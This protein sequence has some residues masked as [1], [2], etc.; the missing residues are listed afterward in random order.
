MKALIF[1]VVLLALCAGGGAVAQDD[2]DTGHEDFDK[3]YLQF[4]KKVKTISIYERGDVYHPSNGLLGTGGRIVEKKVIN[5]EGNVAEMIKYH[6][7]PRYS[8]EKFAFQ[9]DTA[10]LVACTKWDTKGARL[11]QWL[12]END[13]LV[14]EEIRYRSSGSVKYRWRYEYDE[15]LQLL[16]LRKTKPSGKQVRMVQNT[17]DS[18]QRPVNTRVYGK[19]SKLLE[20]YIFQ[21]LDT[22]ENILQVQHYKKGVLES[23]VKNS[24]D[25]TGNMVRKQNYGRYRVL[26]NEQRYRYDSLDQLVCLTALRANGTVEYKV[27]YH[28]DSDKRLEKKIY[29]TPKR[30]VRSE[31]YEY[32]GLGN[33]KFMKSID[34]SGPNPIELL[35]YNDYNDEGHLAEQRIESLNTAQKIVRTHEYVYYTDGELGLE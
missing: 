4:F 2:T 26:L 8:E 25:S 3:N 17:Y 23:S 21:Y 5:R 22:S 34:Q 10:G 27:K 20:R 14:K 6:Y 24:Y 1:S 7:Q 33:V 9:Y 19:G 31:E 12:F 29:E 11:Y 18:L 28:Y 35:Y 15:N 16:A 32:D 30:V 13:T